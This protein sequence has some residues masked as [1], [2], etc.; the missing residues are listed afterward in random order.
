M[1]STIFSVCFIVFAVLFA[2]IGALISRKRHWS[3]VLAKT[4]LTVISA[5]LAFVLTSIFVPIISEALFEPIKA[6][7]EGGALG[8]IFEVIPSAHDALLMFIYVIVAP[9]FFIVVFAILKIVLSLTLYRPV[10][11]LCLVIAGAIKKEKYSNEV[12]TQKQQKASVSSIIMGTVCSLLAYI[13]FLIPVAETAATTSY[14]GKSITKEGMSYELF[15]GLSDNVGTYVI[16]GVGSPIWRGTTRFNINGESIS[17]ATE[18]HFI[19]NFVKALV[20]ISSDDVDTVRNS[21]TT[22]RSISAL[23]PKTSLIPRFTSEFINAANDEWLNGNDFVGIPMPSLATNS[24]SDII[25]TFLECLDNST[26]DTMREDLSVL[27]NVMAVVAE[28]AEFNDSG[29]IDM[30]SI[31]EDKDV[32]SKFSVELLQSPRLSPAMNMFVK[33]HMEASNTYIELPDK[34]SEEHKT[35]VN[36]LY[37]IYKQEVTDTTDEESLNRLADALGKSLAQNDI[38]VEEHEQIALASTFIAEFGDGEN[39]TTEQVSDLIEDYRAK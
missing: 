29:S 8:E 17:A 31:L 10:A 14:V 3:K 30:S 7:L 9:I 34:D 22:F 20:E 18:T 23:A 12:I 39:L 5:V 26:P 38:I 27:L 6:M 11:M 21:A 25:K 32:I 35:L 24:E 33:D 2:A 4:V 13:I 28:N 37:T 19:A 15:D 1:F 36:D 16:R